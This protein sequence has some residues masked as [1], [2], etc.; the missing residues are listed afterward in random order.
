MPRTVS[1]IMTLNPVF[2]PVTSTVAEA[3]RLMRASNIGAVLI[4]EAGKLWGILT[5]RDIVVR[6][7]AQGRQAENT[8]VEEIASRE[9]TT[10]SA[11]DTEYQALKIMQEKAL[12]RLPVMEGDK[13]VGIISLGDLAVDRNRDPRIADALAAIRAAPPNL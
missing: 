9:L 3:A 4:E 10:I 13:V 2:V 6:A 1:E 5:D 12:R 8:N 7:L 11:D